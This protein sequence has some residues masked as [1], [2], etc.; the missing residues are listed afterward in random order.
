MR[1][2]IRNP[3]RDHNMVFGRRI[4]LTTA[5]VASM[6]LLGM[7]TATAAITPIKILGGRTDQVGPAANASFIGFT[8]NTTDA[9]DHYDA[10][11]TATAGGAVTKVNT[12]GLGWFGGIRP[13][14]NQAIFQQYN[15]HD[16]NLHV[17]DLDTMNVTSP[18]AGVNTNNWEFFPSISQDWILFGRIVSGEKRI[19]LF[20]RN[21][22]V[23]TELDSI[24]YPG[25]GFIGPGNVTE[26][27]ATWTKCG[28]TSCNVFYYDLVAETRGRVP[29]PDKHYFYFG[30]AG[31]ASGKLYFVR[32]GNA[33]GARVKIQSWNI[34][35]ADSFTTVAALPAGYDVKYRTFTFVAAGTHDDVY[36]DQLRCSG[37]YYADIYEAP[38]AETA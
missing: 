21:T 37:K 32:S 33:C 2:R 25:T 14:T 18:G 12:G 11:V 9:P 16:S 27:Y 30:S 34:G 4:G 3:G 28:K 29:N 6:A 36:Y 13:D 10:Y 8:A 19:I 20:N 1:L 22:S 31:D 15:R 38:S 24:P 23:R 7:S 26:K 17:I 5:L 35:T